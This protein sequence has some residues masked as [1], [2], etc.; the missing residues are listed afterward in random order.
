MEKPGKFGI[1]SVGVAG[2]GFAVG[3]ELVEEE[4][5]VGADEAVVEGGGVG[6]IELK[7]GTVC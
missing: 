7:E 1:P 3:V 4:E 2:G 6:N 5:I